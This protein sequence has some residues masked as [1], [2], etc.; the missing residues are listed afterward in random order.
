MAKYKP[1][2]KDYADK[3]IKWRKDRNVE[4]YEL[5]SYLKA[6]QS[7]VSRLENCRGVN[8]KLAIQL[9]ARMRD[10][11]TAEEQLWALVP[12]II[13]GNSEQYRGREVA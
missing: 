11:G 4:Q 3:L 7:D 10:M 8:T 1:H 5:A 9:A 2:L 6:H 13:T 12:D